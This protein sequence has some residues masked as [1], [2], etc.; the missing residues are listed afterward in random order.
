M[1]IDDRALR[2]GLVLRPVVP[3]D[4]E[5]VAA[6][7]DAGPFGAVGE[8]SMERRLLDLLRAGGD[9]IEELT[10]VAE[11]DGAVVGH[12]AC[13]RGTLD[14]APAVGLGPISVTPELQRRGIGASLMSAVVATAGRR[15]DPVIVLLGDPDYYGFFG[16]VPAISLGI[17][18]P[19]PWADRYFQAKPL[20]A[21][22]P[23]LAGPF[24]YAPAFSRLDDHERPATDL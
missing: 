17:R 22:H 1:T 24:Q 11:V 14:G 5:F 2:D 7:T 6:L 4:H 23:D 3:A 21:W 8:P 18:S 13:S 19:G 16:F 9:L 20:R 15:G 12:V 10:L